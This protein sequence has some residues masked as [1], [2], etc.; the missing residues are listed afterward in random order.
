MSQVGGFWILQGGP[1][2]DTVRLTHNV[3]S[4]LEYQMQMNPSISPFVTSKERT[5]RQPQDEVRYTKA[6]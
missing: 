4:N 2:T 6:L 1:I 3:D 5:L